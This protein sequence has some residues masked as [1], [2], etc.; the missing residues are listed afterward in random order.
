M[1]GV[2]SLQAIN[3]HESIHEK[4][5]QK[6]LQRNYKKMYMLFKKKAFKKEKYLRT[7]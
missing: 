5:K 1:Q 4:Q 2:I 7:K 3:I 6:I